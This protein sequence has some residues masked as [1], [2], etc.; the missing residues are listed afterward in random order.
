VDIILG[1]LSPQ[2]GR[3]LIDGE[4]VTGENL[5]RWQLNLG[6][7]PQ[8]IYLSDSSLARNIAFGIPEDKLDLEAVE[9]AARIA[10]LHDF[11]ANELVDGYQTF[12][13]ERGVRLSGGQRQRVG[14]ARA[15][16][17]N[18]SVLVLDEATSALDSVT[19]SAV[20]DAIHNLAHEKT[21]IVIA[22]RITTVRECDNIYMLDKGK[23]VDE[24]TYDGL[25]E[26]NERFRAL[27]NMSE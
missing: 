2:R 9:Q 19:E 23:V 4:P 7:V 20:M 6:Y 15:I 3:L 8:Q 13:G 17:H 26:T 5:R 18:P 27:A 1:L 25:I 14:I 11:V 22:H 21:I 24:G 16:Y 12:V 10:N